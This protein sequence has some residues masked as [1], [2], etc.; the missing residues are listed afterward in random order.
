[1]LPPIAVPCGAAQA[2]DVLPATTTRRQEPLVAKP[3]HVN[4]GSLVSLDLLQCVLTIQTS[5]GSF[6]TYVH[7][8]TRRQGQP[9]VPSMVA[10]VARTTAQDVEA[11]VLVHIN[12]TGAIARIVAI[13]RQIK[14]GLQSFHPL[15]GLKR[16]WRQ[17]CR[18]KGHNFNRGWRAIRASFA[19]SSR[20]RTHYFHAGT[21]A[22]APFASTACWR[23]LRNAP[24]AA[25]PP[26]ASNRSSSVERDSYSQEGASQPSL[27]WEL[28]G[29]V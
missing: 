2:E 1:M 18:Q 9:C 22:S 15:R 7:E 26:P 10:C 23:R 29:A 5:A 12:T 4:P 3:C 21:S 11:K 27:S 8:R 6:V 16:S 28:L 20:L 13:F 17:R 25:S 14:F 19:L 24:F